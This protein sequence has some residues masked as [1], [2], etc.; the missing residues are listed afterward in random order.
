MICVVTF[1]SNHD[2]IW[3]E[4]SATLIESI[5]KYLLIDLLID[6]IILIFSPEF[7]TPEVYLTHPRT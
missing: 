6:R 4:N 1:K 3:H 2:N 7:P 5:E